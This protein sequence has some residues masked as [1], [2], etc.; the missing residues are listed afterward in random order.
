MFVT[1]FAGDSGS[2]KM[3]DSRS[4]P[5]PVSVNL[6]IFLVTDGGDKWLNHR[7]MYC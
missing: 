5:F 3:K 1:L 6:R 4:N 2:D 7:S